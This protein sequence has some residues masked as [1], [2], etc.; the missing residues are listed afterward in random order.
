MNTE[1]R[2][3]G[4]VQFIEGKKGGR[5]PYCHSLFIEKEGILIDPASDRKTLEKLASEKNVKEIWLSHWHEDHIMH[6]DLFEDVPIAMHEADSPPMTSETIFL[7]WYCM[8]ELDHPE[9]AANWRLLLK[10]LFNFK[11]REIVRHL[12]DQQEIELNG[13]TVRVLHVPGHSPGSLA[14]YFIDHQLLFLGDY[15][16]TPF[17]PWY[18]DRYSDI[19]Q[20]IDSVN[21]L[22][23]IPAKTWF[24]A[25]EQGV[26]ETDPA[27]RWDNYLAVIEERDQRLLDFLSEPRTLKELGN[28]WIIYGKAR[29]PVAEFLHIE[30]IHM[31]KHADRLIK[32]GKIGLE[33]GR[34]H[35]LI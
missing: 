15:D 30:Q 18:G 6:L 3:F 2:Q 26:F 1:N 29:E 21:R 27:E 4:P 11:P 28:A 24:T 9:L 13:E 14:F 16:L 17:G 34:Y 22:K 20:V 25:H 23:T 12:T 7:D 10:E 19:D 32:Q 31:Q 33:N 35:R 8:N 5:Y